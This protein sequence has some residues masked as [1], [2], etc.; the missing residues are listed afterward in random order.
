MGLRGGLVEGG[1]GK[2]APY[3]Y[4]LPATIVSVQKSLSPGIA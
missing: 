3:L 2:A 1:E 4:H